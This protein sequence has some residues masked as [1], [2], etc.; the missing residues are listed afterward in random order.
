MTAAI[1]IHDLSSDGVER[2]CLVLAP[3]LA[4]VFALGREPVADRSFLP[5]RPLSPLIV[6]AVRAAPKAQR[7]AEASRAGAANGP[8]SIPDLVALAS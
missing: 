3:E 8:N 7:L 6:Q 4:P 5:S 2:Q 1:Y